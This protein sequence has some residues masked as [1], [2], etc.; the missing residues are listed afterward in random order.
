PALKTNQSTQ[1]YSICTTSLGTARGTSVLG[2]GARATG[3]SRTGSPP[4]R[5]AVSRG[6]H[7]ATVMLRYRRI[8]THSRPRR[9][10][11]YGQI[12][13]HLVDAGRLPCRIL[14]L[15]ALATRVHLP[16]QRHGP[17]FRGHVNIIGVQL[18]EPVQG[19]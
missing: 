12:I 15:A 6:R 19:R 18:R 11:S 4:R 2:G 13:D 9:P 3:V 17:I 1:P 7:A 8:V 14:R 10:L 16:V 5:D